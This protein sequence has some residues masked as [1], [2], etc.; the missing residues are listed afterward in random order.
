MKKKNSVFLIIT[1]PAFLLFSFST[2]FPLCRGFFTALRI[3][4]G[5]EIGIL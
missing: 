3:G 4:K 5:M 2:A 1:I